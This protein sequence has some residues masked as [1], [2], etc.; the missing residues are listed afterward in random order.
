[1]EKDCI[2]LTSEEKERLIEFK[3]SD[4]FLKAY[5]LIKEEIG[6]KERK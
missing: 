4:N 5:K 2:H 3:K 6:L 1:M